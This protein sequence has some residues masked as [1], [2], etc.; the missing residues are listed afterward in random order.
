M[1]TVHEV[2]RLTGVSIRALHHYD[3]I[4]LL[5]PTETTA[6]GYRLYDDTALERLQHILLFRELKFSLKDIRIILDDPDFDRERA[7]EQQILLL[8]LRKERLEKLI[9]LAREIKETGVNTLDF[10]AFDTREMAAYEK[11]A[12]E[13]WGH[14]AAWKEYEE[15]RSRLELEDCR[16]AGEGLMEI[17]AELGK[18]QSC[19]PEAEPVQTKI[20]ELQEYISRYFYTCTPEILRG[21]GQMYAAGGKMTENIDKAGGEGTAAFAAEAIRIYTD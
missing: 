4:G 17:F 6:A 15:K 10:S 16:Q 21:L 2:A 5:H 8:K 18:M 12:K 1:R 14:T 13:A 9:R 7:L 19:A 11:Q 3:R 20:R